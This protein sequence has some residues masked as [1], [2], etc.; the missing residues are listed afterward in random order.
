MHIAKNSTP[1]EWIPEFYRKATERSYKAVGRPIATEQGIVWT[2]DGKPW[3][4][5]RPF[6]NPQN[7]MEVMM[8]T[9]YGGSAG[10][11]IML[12]HTSTM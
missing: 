8:N 3:P 7:A 11:V 6:P 10:T 9:K 2:K 4:G 12:I 5:G 1:G